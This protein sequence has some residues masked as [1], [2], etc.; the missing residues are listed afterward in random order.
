MHYLTPEDVQSLALTVENNEGEIVHIYNER[1]K[2]PT[3][4]VIENARYEIQCALEIKIHDSV[5]VNN[6]ENV[7]NTMSFYCYMEKHPKV[8]HKENA[9]LIPNV[10]SDISESDLDQ[11][12]D[13]LAD[14]SS[15]MISITRERDSIED[16]FFNGIMAEIQRYAEST[17]ET[18]I[19]VQLQH[20]QD[21]LTKEIYISFAEYDPED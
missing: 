15:T 7:D 11:I 16:C 14:H 2:I 13:R 17:F 9:A 20:T 18:P 12:C 21:E 6:M 1:N 10:G 8:N 5:I 3:P 19:F 4:K